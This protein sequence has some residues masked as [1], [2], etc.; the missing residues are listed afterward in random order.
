MVRS[1]RVRLSALVK[2]KDKRKERNTDLINRVREYCT[3]FKY[4]YVVTLRNQ[5]NSL[6]K[7]FRKKL[8]DGHFIFGKNK[9]L[10][11]ALGVK[12]QDEINN[13]ICSVSQL[14]KGERALI[15]SNLIPSEMMK[16]C[17]DSSSLEFGR[18]GSIPGISYV[19]TAGCN[20]RE[21]LTLPDTVLHKL[22]LETRIQG[23][24]YELASDFTVCETGVPLTDK[25]AQVLRYLGVPTVKFEIIIEAFWYDGKFHSLNS[26]SPN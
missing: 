22:R 5:R 1:R 18:T 23:E 13:N 9:V 26:C 15:F 17:E 6:L 24:N 12:P 14:L 16:V 11:L 25:Q 2:D 8:G 20:I 4:I 7:L 21:K 19:L 3:C 10:R